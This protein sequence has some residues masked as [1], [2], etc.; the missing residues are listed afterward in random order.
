M[1]SG[2]SDIDDYVKQLNHEMSDRGVS[3]T[4]FRPRGTPATESSLFSSDD[5]RATVERA[6]LIKGLDLAKTTNIPSMRP[7]GFEKLSSFGFG[8]F[9]VTYRN[10]AKTTRRSYC[11]GDTNGWT[12]LFR[13]NRSYVRHFGY[14]SSPRSFN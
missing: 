11:G 9:V 3:D 10:I 7:L 12:P 5:A 14:G 2:N 13:P 1:I 8:S 4:L 6:F